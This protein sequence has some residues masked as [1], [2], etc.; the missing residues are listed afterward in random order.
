MLSLPGVSERGVFREDR[1]TVRDIL[2]GK[3]SRSD[4]KHQPINSESPG[5][6]NKR[7]TH[8]GIS[9]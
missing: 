6:I 5:R 2:A 9:R 8:G 4:E 1:A 7:N 3:F